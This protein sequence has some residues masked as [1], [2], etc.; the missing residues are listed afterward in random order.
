MGV[1]PEHCA[2][3]RHPTQ[4][5]V[6]LLHAG[7]GPTHAVTFVA[8][9]APHAPLGWQA[10]VALPQSASE[11]HARQVCVAT[12]QAGVMPAQVALETQAT[13]VAVAGS[14]A[15][16]MPVQRVT[17][18]VEQRPHEPLA[19]QAGVAPPQS[20]SAPQARQVCVPPSHVGFA[21]PQS[22]LMTHW[23]QVAVAGLHTGVAP[24]HSVVF[25]G[26]HAPHEPFISQAGVAPV[27]SVS[28]WQP[29]QVCVVVL[30]A[31]AAPLQVALDTQA[32]QTPAAVS[33]A[34][35]APVHIATL[36]VEQAPHDPEG[37]H[38]GV[39]PP[40]SPSPAHARHTCVV[41]LHTG[42]LPEQ[43]AFAMQPTHDPVETLQTA[44]EPL[45][46]AVF[47]AEQAPHDPPG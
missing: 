38:A 1:V 17:F 25:V 8:E 23:T 20:E 15:G 37:S 13:Q 10:G 11:L 2:A 39:P 40:H 6:T 36:V 42:A 33:Q 14:Q 24:V 22:A 46:F 9:Q 4:E 34:G 29:R 30:Q 35:V 32:T 7:V 47:V 12:L 19:W 26:E 28:L 45:H 44:V 27:H 3:D 43:S 16:V 41:A 21:P 31:G 5:P 18:V